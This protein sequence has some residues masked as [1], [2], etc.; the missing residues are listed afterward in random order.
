ML[1]NGLSGQEEVNGIII[2]GDYISGRLFYSDRPQGPTFYGNSDK[3][4][5]TQAN[6]HKSKLAV[7][8]GEAFRHI[9]PN[10]DWTI[11][12]YE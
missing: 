12:I 9:Y 4:V 6:E 2:G 10:H 8:Y 7:D 3:E 1:I 11:R 5:S